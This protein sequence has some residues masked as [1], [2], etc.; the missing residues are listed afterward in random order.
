MVQ[1]TICQSCGA[2]IVSEEEFGT[3]ADGSLNYEYCRKC[4]QNGKF[5][6]PNITMEEMIQKVAKEMI[7][8][9]K[10]PPKYAFK[11]AKEYIPDLKRW[12]SGSKS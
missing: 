5:T 7:E 4:Y 9:E 1:K 8:V 3:N 11:I 12:R 2:P 6:E 10:I